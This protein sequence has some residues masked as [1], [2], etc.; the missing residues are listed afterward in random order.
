MRPEVHSRLAETGGEPG[1]LPVA[2]A[3]SDV[4]AAVARAF[5]ALDAARARWCLLRGEAELASPGA[6]I[7]LLAAA[8][9]LARLESAL[10]PLGFR[11]VRTHGRGTHSFF[12]AFDE[13]DGRW[14]KLDVVTELAYGRFQELRLAGAPGCLARSRRLRGLTVL[15]ADDAF[16]TLLLH[17]LLDRTAFGDAERRTL[18]E[19]ASS[20]SACG[21]L[22][23]AL[24]HAL[25]GPPRAQTLLDL[26]RA[27]DWAGLESRALPL[28][29]AWIHRR[30]LTARL[31]SFRN[32]A[33]RRAG[34]YPPL[35]RR[36]P[37][38]IIRPADS[39]LAEALAA[40][41]FFPHRLVR[42]PQPP[43]SVVRAL[44][45]ARWHAARGRLV[46]LEVPERA[47]RSSALARV[48]GALDL[49]SLVDALPPSDRARRAA[50]QL[51]L[52]FAG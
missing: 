27:G 32:A 44:L 16:W 31:R 50:A 9:D 52:R 18:L 6:D 2:P 26:A 23:R 45:A 49:T 4:Q 22:A 15:A 39:D 25:A 29:S 1:A 30:P 5:A 43:Q 14:I 17:C 35:C 41:W 37:T 8:A 42:V 20:A 47:R 51:W 40:T 48:S 34:R 38:V 28:R 21:P 24:E 46:L 33:V 13:L 12:V 11:R 3:S 36:G 7:D 10:A 19:L